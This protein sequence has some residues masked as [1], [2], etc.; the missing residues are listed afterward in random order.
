MR[1]KSF[2]IRIVHACPTQGTTSTKTMALSGFRPR[3]GVL[4]SEVRLEDASRTVAQ[5][6]A[7]EEPQVV[8]FDREEIGG[9]PKWPDLSP[10]WKGPSKIAGPENVKT[11][12]S[13]ASRPSKGSTSA[14]ETV[15]G[16][17]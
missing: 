16:S 12:S 6:G 4:V 1:R 2:R 13:P 9:R 7:R 3:T 15:R 17:Q 11:W 5:T 8:V 14:N 10:H